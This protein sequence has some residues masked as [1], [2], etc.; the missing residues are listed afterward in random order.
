MKPIDLE[1]LFK[2]ADHP[3]DAI[4]QLIPAYPNI[5]E[6]GGHYGEDT[7]RL[8][9]L[10]PG[11]EIFTFE[12]NPIAFEKLQKNVESYPHIHLFPFALNSF[13]GTAEFYVQSHYGNDGASSILPAS[14]DYAESTHIHDW[15]YIEQKVTVP[16]VTLDSW[17]SCNKIDH[18]DL[19]WLD[20]EGVELQV[21]RSGPH[22]LKSVRAI[23]I[24]VNFQ[25]FRIG[26][27]QYPALALF[28]KEQGFQEVFLDSRE[29]WCQ[30]NAVYLSLCYSPDLR[31]KPRY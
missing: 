27:T 3:I 22:L 29:C 1:L 24:E 11:A 16:C 23:Y 26:M 21:L 6:A 13:D 9:N 30:C 20:L 7:L 15:W 4:R 2:N 18:I 25:E 31:S 5:L 12:P 28:L 14:P 10:W 8:A 17:A 19:M